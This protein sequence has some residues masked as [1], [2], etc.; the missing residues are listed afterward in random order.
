MSKARNGCTL[1]WNPGT[2]GGRDMKIPEA[3]WL[4]HLTPGSVRG[5][6]SREQERD[7]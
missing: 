7:A 4:P 2:I 3:Y 6:A 5:L 1:T